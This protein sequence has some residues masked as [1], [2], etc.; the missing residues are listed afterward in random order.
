MS[1]HGLDK[2]ASDAI[3]AMSLCHDSKMWARCVEV[4]DAW[5][6]ARGEMPVIAATLYAQSLQAVGRFEEAVRWAK[7]AYDKMPRSEPVAVCAARSTYAQA[8]ARVGKFWHARKV[9]KEMVAV[10]LSDPET[11]E[12]QGHITLAI[13]D[14]WKEGWAMHEARLEGRPMPDGLIQWDGKTKGRI[15]VLHEQGIGDAVLF[16]RWMEWVRETSGHDVVWFGPDRIMDRWIGELQGVVIGDRSIQCRTPVDFAV[17]SMSLP[18]YAG[19]DSPANVPEPSA[20][21]SLIDARSYRERNEKVRVGVCW[22]GS[23]GGWHDFERSFSFEEFSPVFGDLRGVEFVNLTHEATTCEGAPFSMVVFSD[24]YQCAEVIAGLDLVVTVD[25]AVAHL[26]GSLGV[27]A[28]VIAP[29]V[30]DWRYSWPRGG[31]SAF[32]KSVTVIRRRRGDDF[33]CIGM[34]RQIVEKY[35][36]KLKLLNKRAA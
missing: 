1:F 9:L 12:K 15:A 11:R 28:I 27:P 3:E 8:L 22:K 4:G 17:F 34:A 33:Q 14:R 18:H 32:Y 36:A 20:P 13:S 24:V 29:T 30:P 31:D 19:C 35:A 26:A 25:T 7:V 16:A 21:Q 5:L 23:S 2:A 10:P 6:D